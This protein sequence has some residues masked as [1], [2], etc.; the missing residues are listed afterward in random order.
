MTHENTKS[1]KKC[2]KRNNETKLFYK[3][4]YSTKEYI[5]HYKN[6]PARMEP[7]CALKAGP[8]PPIKSIS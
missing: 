8:S 4:N 2:T 5:K 3:R 6:N 1:E 7:D